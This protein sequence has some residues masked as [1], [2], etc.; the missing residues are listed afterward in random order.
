MSQA[1]RIETRCYL[2][3]ALHLAI[4][5]KLAN[6]EDLAV[7]VTNRIKEVTRE[8]ETKAESTLDTLLLN[9]EL[10]SR[11]R[12]RGVVATLKPLIDEYYDLL[13]TEQSLKRLEKVRKDRKHRFLFTEAE[14]VGSVLRDGSGATE[15]QEENL[16]DVAGAIPR[17]IAPGVTRK[18]P[19]SIS[20]YRDMGDYLGRPV[21][22][23]AF[24][25]IPGVNFDVTV[26]VWDSFTLHPS[27]RAKLRNFAFLR[28]TLYVKIMVSGSPFHMGKTLVSYQPY[29]LRNGTL[30]AHT[31]NYAFTGAAY[32]PLL[33]NYLSQAPGATTMDIKEN[34]PLIVECPFI[35][36][37]PINRLFNTSA[38]AL[39]A[40]TA[41]DDFQNMGSLHLFS[42]NPLQAV[43]AGSSDVAFYVYAWM[44]DVVLSGLTGTQVAITT[45]AEPIDER[46]V[47]PVES[48]T[49]SAISIAGALERVPFIKPY[50]YASKMM[51]SGLNRFASIFGWSRPDVLP[52]PRYVKNTAWQ[53]GAQTIAHETS[54]KLSILPSQELTVDPSFMGSNKDEMCIAHIASVQTY[55]RSLTWATTDTP[56]VTL[57]GIVP[58]CPYL[59]TYYATLVTGWSQ[60]TAMCFAATPFEFWRGDIEITFQVVCSQYHRGKLAFFYEPNAHQNVLIDALVEPNKQFIKFLDIQESQSVTLTIAW[61]AHR[62]WLRNPGVLN[63]NYPYATTLVTLGSFIN[64]YVGVTPV[65]SIQSPDGS[66]VEIN[67]F[68]RCPN[69][70]VNGFVSGYIPNTRILTEAE[71]M[72]TPL[73][74]D[75]FSDTLNESSAQQTADT[76]HHFG[77]RI[78]SFRQLCKRFV[79][80]A[81][82]EVTTVAGGRMTMTVIEPIIPTIK[83]YYGVAVGPT[84]APMIFDYLRYAYVGLRGG[85]KRRF[86]TLNTIAGMTDCATARLR[87]VKGTVT[88]PSV[89]TAAIAT[90]QSNI[91]CFNEGAVVFV[92]GAN[93]GWEVEFPCYTNNLFLF[94]FA[95]DTVGTNN[96]DEMELTWFRDFDFCF[97]SA[98][99]STVN[100][101]MIQ[102]F[103]IGE[104]F[105]FLRFQGS[106]YRSHTL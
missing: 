71:P 40:G 39:A 52:E 8:L 99:S 37:K 26:E 55:W 95:V 84:Y 98:N 49:S 82:T 53:N 3:A 34:E 51:L 89:T 24:S 33:I 11:R 46:V 103:A 47:G 94:S 14:A 1:L 6:Q 90:T 56:M 41:Y 35:S 44:E 19:D 10:D 86:R 65:T 70:D 87:P 62:S 60:P 31:A 36:T 58:I 83:T 64:G 69:L 93:P 77:E 45:E 30:V 18:L 102:E 100:S 101:H 104:D 72:G 9:A 28:G 66:S 97:F 73:V 59:S 23:D 61:N 17:S 79:T 32:R 20:T 16:S 81:F 75:S 50:A 96:T 15:H 57:L 4:P 42:I 43:S 68:V 38:L 91:S 80:H 13:V 5:P 2:D 74:P 88:I 67:I 85:I 29:P 105:S 48:L 106:P 12:R 92:N 78:V 25:V 76:M 22:I 63:Y 27:V 21:Q 54:S 7:Y